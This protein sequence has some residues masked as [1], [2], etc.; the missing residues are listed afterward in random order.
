[1]ARGSLLAR[2]EQSLKQATQN[3]VEKVTLSVLERAYNV[4]ATNDVDAAIELLQSPGHIDLL[5]KHATPYAVNALLAV[6]ALSDK[7]MSDVLK[8]MDNSDVKK[9][10]ECL[11]KARR[12]QQPDAKNIKQFLITNVFLLPESQHLDT[13]DLLAK[14]NKLPLDMALRAKRMFLV[15]FAGENWDDA[16]NHMNVLSTAIDKFERKKPE[17]KTQPKTQPNEK[18]LYSYAALAKKFGFQDARV[19]SI[20]LSQV[21]ADKSEDEIK[22]IRGLFLTIKRK[23]Y[24]PVKHFDKLAPLFIDHRLNENKPKYENMIDKILAPYR[25][26][27]R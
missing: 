12:N 19:F 16:I 26:Y 6:A 3:V 5:Y 18:V 10:Q 15:M 14:I 1:M 2:H 24:L 21:L 22:R 20:R 4:C 27:H 23:N 11:D 25:K 17:T 9:L 8:E 7:K 13:S